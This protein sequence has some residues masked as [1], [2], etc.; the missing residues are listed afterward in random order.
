MYDKFA[1]AITAKASA[2]VFIPHKI[3]NIY[4]RITSATHNAAAANI[5][6]LANS[7]TAATAMVNVSV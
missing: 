3:K 5:A 1:G 6:I 2:V 4:H 7:T